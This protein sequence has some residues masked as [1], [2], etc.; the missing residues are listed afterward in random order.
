MLVTV[1]EGS[2]QQTIGEQTIEGGRK[3]KDMADVPV[4]ACACHGE[5]MYWHRDARRVAGGSWRCTIKRRQAHGRYERTQARR[6]ARRRYRAS[7]K[8]RASQLRYRFSDKG[9]AR[10]RRRILTAS[11]R[12]REQR[13]AEWGP[14]PDNL[15][16]FEGSLFVRQSENEEGATSQ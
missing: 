11:V 6:L 7:D 2:H 16:E 9:R 8:G 14:L 1:F 5:E 15:F 4:A 12:R 3:L 10:E 13:L